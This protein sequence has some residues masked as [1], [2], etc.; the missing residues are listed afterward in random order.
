MSQRNRPPA[1]SE[2]KLSIGALAQATSI[3]VATLRTWERRYG[4]PAPERKPSGQRLYPLS[5]VERLQR[6]AAALARG[7]R[8]AEIVGASDA[9]LTA[10]LNAPAAQTAPPN[11]H[12]MGPVHVEDLLVAV[13]DL[14]S[15]R[16]TRLLLLDQA[17]LGIV[18]HLDE[19]V[20]PLLRAAGEEWKRGHIEVR[21]EHFLSERV[22]DLLRA[23]RLPFEERAQGPLVILA[24][25]TGE[26]HALGVHM[27]ALTL[28]SAGCRVLVLG[29]DT[30]V[31]ELPPL[32]KERHARAVA[33]SVS[34]SSAGPEMT[35]QLTALRRALPRHVTLIAGGQ[36]AAPAR[37][38]TH[39]PSLAALE[40]WGREATAAAGRQ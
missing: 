11:R 7:H 9:E 32:V 22:S 27:A 10:L 37:G 4:F 30:P 19:R 38:V 6:I 28:A 17:R 33:I 31:R 13:R 14:D 29:A 18:R 36:G 21:H 39:I 12:D 26:R 16:L 25:L 23:L 2:A 3:P 40:Q 35:A 1:P 5:C 34:L 15:E 20:A 24:T 8:A